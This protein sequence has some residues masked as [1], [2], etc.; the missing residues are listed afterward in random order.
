[1]IQEDRRV[2]DID[3][4]TCW[5]EGYGEVVGTCKVD[6]KDGEDSIQASFQHLPLFLIF[7]GWHY[8]F[9]WSPDNFLLFMV[10]YGHIF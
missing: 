10:L 9:S 4:G 8:G 2:E 5:E 6:N 7:L 1:M 3:N